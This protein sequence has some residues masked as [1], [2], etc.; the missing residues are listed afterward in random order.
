MQAN[1]QGSLYIKEARQ[2]VSRC[3]RKQLA[4]DVR[5]TTCKPVD[6]DSVAQLVGV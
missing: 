1:R 2:S 3:N 5:A 4:S 6:C